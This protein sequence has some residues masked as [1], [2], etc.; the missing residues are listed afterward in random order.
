MVQQVVNEK[1]L[2]Q[3]SVTVSHV[4]SLPTTHGQLR[5]GLKTSATS[6]LDE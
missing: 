1:M 4:L 6:L 3:L 5:N 2:F